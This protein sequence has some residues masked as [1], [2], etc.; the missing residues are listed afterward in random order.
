MSNIILRF[1]FGTFEI[2]NTMYFISNIL[3]R[4]KYKTCCAIYTSL[5]YMIR[6]KVGYMKYTSR[7]YEF[8]IF[9]SGLPHIYEQLR[10]NQFTHALETADNMLSASE[11]TS[12]LCAIFLFR[13]ECHY[14]DISHEIVKKPQNLLGQYEQ[15]TRRYMDIFQN[16]QEQETYNR[17]RAKPNG[18]MVKG[19]DHGLV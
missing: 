13:F 3:L 14:D 2:S 11:R 19:E 16:L 7:I 10:L 18:L 9:L 12:S 5:Q 15:F 6:Y 17:F 4:R 8:T 1:K